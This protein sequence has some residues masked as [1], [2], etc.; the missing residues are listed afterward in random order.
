MKQNEAYQ[1]IRKRFQDGNGL[2]IHFFGSGNG[3][4]FFSDFL[5]HGEYY[6]GDAPDM[7]LR[8]GNE[9]IILEHFEFDGF[10]VRKGKGSLG[11]Q[12]LSRIE[13]EVSTLA[14]SN[15]NAFLVDAIKANSTLD[16]LL[17]NVKSSFLRHYSHIEMYKK[18]LEDS[19]L[20][21]ETTLIKVMFLLEDV[22][23]LGTL[24]EDKDARKTGVQ[25]FMLAR[26]R[27]FLE[28]VK[29]YIKVN[30]ILVFS[31][32]G[33]RDSVWFIDTTELE[34]YEKQ[35]IDYRKMYYLP[36]STQVMA[37]DSTIP[38]SESVNEIIQRM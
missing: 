12:E 24:F 33:D 38:E 31:P 18:N 20:I 27:E 34:F 2:D 1:A 32:Y 35:A 9:A 28:W 29:N 4:R 10:P 25:Y 21:G 6:L 3:A 22:S 15:G 17:K 5:E 14:K 26:C 7:L 13:R 19:G 30:Y 8:K 36:S 23:P 16:N 11:R 37:I